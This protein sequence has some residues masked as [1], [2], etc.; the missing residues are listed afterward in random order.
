MY[1]FHN[2]SI[3]FLYHAAID[4]VYN[5]VQWSKIDLLIQPPGVSNIRV[6]IQIDTSAGDFAIG[7]GTFPL[8]DSPDFITLPVNIHRKANPIT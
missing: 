2:F 8:R 5:A 4:P 1:I 6:H 3:K 7:D